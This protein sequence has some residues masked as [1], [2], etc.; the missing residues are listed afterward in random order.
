MPSQVGNQFV[1]LSHLAANHSAAHLFIPHF[2]G[3]FF[4]V[5]GFRLYKQTITQLWCTTVT[6]FLILILHAPVS[7][8]TKEGI[9]GT[10]AGMLPSCSCAPSR[11]SDKGVAGAESSSR[12]RFIPW[13]S[14]KVF[15]CQWSRSCWVFVQ[16]CVCEGGGRTHACEGNRTGM[17]LHGFDLYCQCVNVSSIERAL[18]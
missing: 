2:Y 11:S 7:R 5:Q 1:V 15:V 9:C 8:S 16:V 18:L 17:N 13:L 14:A 10:E 3:V 12:L 4:K 6:F